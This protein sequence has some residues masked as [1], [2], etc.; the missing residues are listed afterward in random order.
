MPTNHGE[1]ENQMAA[2]AQGILFLLTTPKIR[3]IGTV[4]KLQVL[5]ASE[6]VA[7]FLR[8]E[9]RRGRWQDSMPGGDRLVQE[10]GVGRNTV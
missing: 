5:T 9:I 6:Q 7:A 10:L 8:E 3:Q 1:M 2:M 4:A